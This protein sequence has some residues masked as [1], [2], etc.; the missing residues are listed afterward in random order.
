MDEVIEFARRYIALSFEHSRAMW[1]IKDD[2]E[3]Q[4]VLAE[5]DAM[6]AVP[7]GS[8]E[9]R[10]PGLSP[11]KLAKY[12]H[13]Y[14][15]S[16]HV[17]TLLFQVKEYEH[18]KLGR[19][20]LCY[21]SILTRDADADVTAYHLGYWVQRTKDGL[22]FISLTDYC[23]ACHATGVFQGKKCPECHGAGWN[24]RDGIKIGDPGKLVAVRKLEAPTDPDSLEEYNRE[25]RVAGAQPKK[26]GKK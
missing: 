3:Y 5:L 26:P 6:F 21:F 24:H 13:D 22:K 8:G 20:F 23:P 25:E 15:A 10:S 2:R 4:K 14:A 19:I 18:P 11:E 1:Q 7:D 9:G 17:P 12:A 16:A